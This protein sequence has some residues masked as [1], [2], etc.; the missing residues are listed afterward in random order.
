MVARWEMERGDLE[1]PNL[2]GGGLTS[3]PAFLRS[4]LVSTRCTSQASAT[5]PSFILHHQHPLLPSIWTHLLDSAGSENACIIQTV[6]CVVRPSVRPSTLYQ[7]RPTSPLS[8]PLPPLSPSS[9]PIMNTLLQE[10]SR[11]ETKG[12]TRKLLS[13][14]KKTTNLIEEAQNAIAAGGPYRRFFVLEE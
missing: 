13:D 9:E 14:V 7:D 2:E 6:N 5:T 10:Q 12:N 11:L 1:V 4:F 8:V 3:A